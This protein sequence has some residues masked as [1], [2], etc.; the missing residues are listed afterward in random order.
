[1]RPATWC[2]LSR[3]SG[4]SS[5]SQWGAGPGTMGHRTK[6]ADELLA[7]LA[8]EFELINLRNAALV[9]E[10]E[11][12]RAQMGSCR[13]STLPSTSVKH[14]GPL[15][16]ASWGP[17]QLPVDPPVAVEPPT[18]PVAVMTL[19]DRLKREASSLSR[20]DLSVVANTPV[21]KTS[22]VMTLGEKAASIWRKP[23]MLSF[24]GTRF[25][26]TL[27]ATSGLLV[28]ERY[29]NFYDLSRAFHLLCA[30]H[31]ITINARE[32]CEMDLNQQGESNEVPPE[33][34]A[35]FAQAITELNKDL[36]MATRTQEPSQ[37]VM[38]ETYSTLMSGHKAEY[39]L[40]QAG[41]NGELIEAVT[42]MRD[43]LLRE[44]AV[45]KIA[46]ATN[47]GC[48][49]LYVPNKGRPNTRMETGLRF[50]DPFIGV[51]ILCNATVI[52]IST[53]WY[54][55]NVAWDWCELGFTLIFLLEVMVKVRVYGLAQHFC[56]SDMLWNVFDFLVVVLAVADL[57]V[58]LL[59]DVLT[60]GN[61][62]LVRL[63]RFAR[64]TKLVRVL[65]LKMF[66][67][68]ALLV[69]GCLAGFRTLLWAMV[70]LAFILF[71]LGVLLK[72]SF[73]ELGAVYYPHCP[74][75]TFFPEEAA[76]L[77]PN[78]DC[79]RS[80]QKLDEFRLQLFGNVPR[81]MFTV[82]RC[83]TDGCSFPSGTPLVPSIYNTHGLRA[84]LLFSLVFLFVIFGLFNLIMA[85]FVQNTI[86]NAKLDDERR[87]EARSTEH[88]RVARKLQEVI[89]MF[90]AGESRPVS[91]HRLV[92]DDEPGL[93]SRLKNAFSTRW[94][95][96][97]SPRREPLGDGNMKLS[98]KVSHA[99]F[100][101]ILQKP[102]VQQLLDDLDIG[103]TSR[104]GLWDVLDADGD[105]V[106]EVSEL[107]HGLLKLRGAAEK[108]EHVAALLA[109]RSL[110][111]NMKALQL[112]GLKQQDSI[113]MLSS[114][115]ER[116]ESQVRRIS[117]ATNAMPST[118]TL[119]DEI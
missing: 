11:S 13:A 119:R 55:G 90:C 36:R 92:P 114:A 97:E 86:E 94:S 42:K 88:V 65:K 71:A 103:Y 54:A 100:H 27:D 68:L 91:D 10:L 18:S 5:K 38:F 49:H 48:E 44:D 56:G 53:D 98:L 67:E 17:E 108:M 77:E 32:I 83:F 43:I 66:K 76:T 2:V 19:G 115:H 24:A 6:R 26:A 109:I 47:T 63:L 110:Q 16:D 31:K 72:G 106:L 1:M 61:V 104:G 40:E 15:P 74:D 102:E 116:M 8:T 58:T 84:V 57:I 39:K 64:L 75:V 45:R 105:G 46:V 51:V 112:L 96:K 107:V 80:A 95:V 117:K 93:V 50:M 35:L 111:R 73:G 60:L 87:R 69:N 89:L 41:K 30:K 14:L 78:D 12:L 7:A 81:S 29:E 118:S 34:E 37:E 85:V 23:A 52:G 33:Q 62:T 28:E 25:D 79:S 3:M 9:K 82:F 21:N 101:K 4:S 59:G 20:T 99:A 22:S 113:D 70:F